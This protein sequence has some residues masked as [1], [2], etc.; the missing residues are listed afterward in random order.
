[1]SKETHHFCRAT[2]TKIHSITNYHIWTQALI[3][4]NKNIRKTQDIIASKRRKYDLITEENFRKLQKLLTERALSEGL[5]HIHR[6][7]HGSSRISI[8]D[9]PARNTTVIVF[10]SGTHSLDSF[11]RSQ[12]V[13]RT[14]PGNCSGIIR[15][16]SGIIRVASGIIRVG[17]G[18]TVYTPG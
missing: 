17:S 1:M 6:S 3:L 7:H 12:M 18:I 8:R 11:T 9:V 13:T 15:V 2:L 10:Y 4:L 5:S 14:I 16:V